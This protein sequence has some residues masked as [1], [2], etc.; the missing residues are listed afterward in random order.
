MTSFPAPD[1]ISARIDVETGDVRIAAEHRDETVVEVTPSDPARAA[2]RAAAEQTRVAYA[3][4]LLQVVGPRHGAFTSSRKHGSVQVIVHLPTGSSIDVTLALGAT[5]VDGD[6]GDC[7][8]KTSAGDIRVGN[9]VTADLRTS[10]GAIAAGHI[11][12]EARCTT[13]SGAVAIRRAGG[14]TEVKNSN[15]DTRIGDSD[16]ALRVKSANGSVSVDNVHAGAVVTTANGN[17]RVGCADAGSIQ[18][19][20]SL[21]RIDVGI[22]SGIAARLDL[23]TSFGNVHNHLEAA[24]RPAADEL[25]IE[26]QAQTSA[27]DIEVTRITELEQGS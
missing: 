20:T 19:K 21:G 3:D 27:G 8:V 13:G 17:L 6:L 25:T 1:P 7:R 24:E 15:G 18:L 5:A 11:S 10:L 16:G 26:V 14:R 23:H 4:G 9:A 22:A 2:D 12:G